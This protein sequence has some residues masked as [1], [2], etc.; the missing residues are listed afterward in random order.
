MVVHK[1]IKFG[2]GRRVNVG[3][4]FIVHRDRSDYPEGKE[5]LAN[6]ERR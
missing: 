6:R 4:G 3:S 2:E 1:H 5:G